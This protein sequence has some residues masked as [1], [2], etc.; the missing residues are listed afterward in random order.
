MKDLAHSNVISFGSIYFQTR[1]KDLDTA[2][3]SL[4]EVLITRKELKIG[5]TTLLSLLKV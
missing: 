3:L 2:L 1:I 4:L 5:L